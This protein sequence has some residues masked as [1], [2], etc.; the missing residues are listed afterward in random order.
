[1]TVGNNASPY[2][3]RVSL[4][5]LYSLSPYHLR[6]IDPS[7]R[8]IAGA[9]QTAGTRRCE[10]HS[11]EASRLRSRVFMQTWQVGFL[12]EWRWLRWRVIH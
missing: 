1:M 2:Q 11:I 5:Y 4:L 9:C 8:L 12:P 7:F 3:I 6:S 10:L